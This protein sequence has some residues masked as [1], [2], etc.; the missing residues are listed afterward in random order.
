MVQFVD[1]SLTLRFSTMSSASRCSAAR[2]VPQTS[3][4]VAV[5]D[6]RTSKPSS[7]RSSHLPGRRHFRL[8]RRT[9]SSPIGEIFV[10][11]GPDGCIRNQHSRLK[12][13]HDQDK[14][15]GP[16]GARTQHLRIKSPLLY[17][18]S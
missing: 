4:F 1:R 16:S 11:R 12:T 13:G 15:G 14:C 7:I 5:N 17:Q 8:L 6:L 10:R 18:M 9:S 3:R 2:P